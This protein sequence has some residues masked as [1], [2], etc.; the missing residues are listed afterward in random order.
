[1]SELTASVS[2]DRPRT[3][4][5]DTLAMVTRAVRL[6]TRNIEALLTAVFL[7]A[8][9][10]LMFV[11]L[12]GGAIRTSTMY[13]D[14][15]VPGVLVLCIGM[16]SAQTA[17]GVTQDMSEGVIDRFRSM[18]VGGAAVLSGHVAA[19]VVRNA[20]A[21]VVTLGVALLIGFRPDAGLLDWLGTAGVLLLFVFAM[22]WV[23]ATFGLI[24]KTP[25]G[26]NGFAFFVLFL[27]YPSSGFVPI[28]TMP[29]W[30]HGFAQHQPVTPVIDTARALLLG[31]PVG[32]GAVLVIAWCLGLA[33][34]SMAA[35]ALLFR[36]LAR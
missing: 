20:V 8:M 30:I 5:G 9:I 21:V 32:N 26:A 3:P 12:F 35:S 13:V 11:Y 15:V 24:T 1:M 31:T 2:W 7:P 34:V 18:D 25:E 6:S 33:A 27:P 4:F 17:V 10:M 22:S 29:G 23:S 16:V 19:S 36:R 28:E 14:Y